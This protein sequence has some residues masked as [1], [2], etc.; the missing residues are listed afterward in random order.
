MLSRNFE[1]IAGYRS[2]G[3]TVGSA[4]TPDTRIAFF[5]DQIPYVGSSRHRSIESE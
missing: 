4:S 5:D 3:G 1:L 2:D